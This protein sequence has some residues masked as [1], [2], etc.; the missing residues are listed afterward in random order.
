MDLH[1]S[2]LTSRAQGSLHPS[3]PGKNGA[4][5]A[6]SQGFGL[7]FD[8]QGRELFVE[9]AGAKLFGWDQG[10][11]IYLVQDG[12]EQDNKKSVHNAMTKGEVG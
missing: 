3:L 11:L 9:V 1:F 6:S 2:T 10:F 4:I 12:G 7:V 8:E 5:H